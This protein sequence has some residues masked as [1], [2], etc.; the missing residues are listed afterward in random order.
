MCFGR[1]IILFGFRKR[2]ELIQRRLFFE[3]PEMSMIP[4]RTSVFSFPR[5]SKLLM[6]QNR[7][8]IYK[9]SSV[10]PKIIRHLKIPVILVKTRIKTR[11]PCQW[12]VAAWIGIS[13]LTLTM[14]AAPFLTR[15]TGPG[16]W[17]LI[18][19]I[20]RSSR[21]SSIW[22]FRSS[23]SGPFN[24]PSAPF[25]ALLFRCFPKIIQIQFIFQFWNELEKLKITKKWRQNLSFHYYQF[26]RIFLR[27]HSYKIDL[28]WHSL[29][30]VFH[31]YRR[32]IP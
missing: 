7:T 22:I 20:R 16:K 2:S 12:T 13:F 27:N 29:S 17:L 24:F 5:I 6:R 26:L 9:S 18:V 21:P 11:I 30:L 8:L 25:G 14:T 32:R 3:S 1:G 4:K 19:I 15:M 31:Q 23:S 28:F 10:H